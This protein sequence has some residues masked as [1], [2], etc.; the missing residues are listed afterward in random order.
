MTPR[1]MDKIQPETQS[2][3]WMLTKGYV[4]RPFADT[5]PLVEMATLC[6]KNLAIKGDNRG[7]LE[8]HASHREQENHLATVASLTSAI[9]QTN[10]VEQLF[11]PEQGFLASLLGPDLV[12]QANPH[13]RVG[14]PKEVRDSIDLHRD[15]F[16]GSSV[17]H[18][19]AWFPLLPLESGCGLLLGEGTHREPS[20]GVREKTFADDFRS[21]VTKGSVANQLGYVYRALTDDTIENLDP[22]R[23]VLVAPPW[24]SYC[25]FFGCMVHGGTNESTVT[26]WTIDVRFSRLDDGS[27]VRPGY[28]RTFSR[29]VIRQVAEDFGCA[30]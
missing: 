22:A 9:N 30:A 20:M 24:G 8:Y 2:L 23:L 28:F 10:Y 4:V 27:A 14:R 12:I 6:G 3:D 19:N 18:L 16:Y 25:L 7:L 13:L 29:G 15:S 11:R 17:W 26:R 1:S 5:A 21:T